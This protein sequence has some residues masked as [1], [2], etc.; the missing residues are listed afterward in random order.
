VS[1]YILFV[2]T[3]LFSLA[4]L[5]RYASIDKNIQHMIYAIIPLS[6]ALATDL[7]RM[8]HYDHPEIEII[9]LSVNEAQQKYPQG[10]DC[11]ILIGLV[12]PLIAFQEYE[13]FLTFPNQEPRAICTKGCKGKILD[14]LRLSLRPP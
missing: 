9:A 1:H 10:N 5:K 3:Y 13:T 7:P 6:V 12:E 2:N 11:C 4:F 14:L 8:I